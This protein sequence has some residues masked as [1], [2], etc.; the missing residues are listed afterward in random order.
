MQN[1]IAGAAVLAVLVSPSAVAVTG[2]LDVNAT[3]N[4]LQQ[5]GSVIADQKFSGNGVA[6]NGAGLIVLQ[7]SAVIANYDISR[8]RVINN[9][10]VRA[11]QNFSGNGA[12]TNG[13]SAGLLFQ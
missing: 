6:R 12:A 9:G 8:N 10:T 11:N 1:L 5:N 7:P 3:E 13:A 2:R 4:N